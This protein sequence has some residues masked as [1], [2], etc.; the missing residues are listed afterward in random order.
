MRAEKP[1]N[2][3]LKSNNYEFIERLDLSDANG[4][5]DPDSLGKPL[6]SRNLGVRR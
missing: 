6:F 5:G 2:Y 1:K 4:D 3:G